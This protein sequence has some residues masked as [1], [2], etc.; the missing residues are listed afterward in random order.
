MRTIQIVNRSTVATDAQ[1]KPIV[2]ALQIQVSRDFAPIWDVDAHLVFVPKGQPAAPGTWQL[3]ILD[4][5]DQ[6]GCLGYHDLSSDGQPIGK[7]F[8][9]TDLTAGSMLSVTISHELLELLADPY[10]DRVVVVDLGHLT[11]ALFCLEICD[12]PESD[13]LGYKI[14]GIQ[15][16]DFVTPYWFHKTPIPGKKLDFCGHITK[17]FQILHNGYIGTMKISESA[18]GWT[19][20]TAEGHHSRTGM[21]APVG[22][23][24]ERRRIGHHNWK[25]STCE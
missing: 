6:A 16:S 3:L 7:V 21:A 9:R 1:L 13:E 18:H 15:V 20:I 2:D 25:L 24:R 8:A 22:S 17:P 11:G 23:R 14:N 10:V 5:A 12:A 19:Q 4:D